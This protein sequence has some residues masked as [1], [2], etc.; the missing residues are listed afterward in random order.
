MLVSK[1]FFDQESFL[2]LWGVSY[3]VKVG[4]SRIAKPICCDMCY[5]WTNSGFS[6]AVHTDKQNISS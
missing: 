3:F 6:Y 2:S 5:E 4:L 1:N